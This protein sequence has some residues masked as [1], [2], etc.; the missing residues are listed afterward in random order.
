MRDAL[1]LYTLCRAGPFITH[2]FLTPPPFD[3]GCSISLNR[4]GPKQQ[5]LKTNL[6][7]YGNLIINSFGK[8]VK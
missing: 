8:R 2:S 1:K 5:S 4:D 7:L 6:S 3:A